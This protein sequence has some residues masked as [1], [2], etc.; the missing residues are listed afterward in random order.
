MIILSFTHFSS[1]RVSQVCGVSI[2]MISLFIFSDLRLNSGIRSNDSEHQFIT[3][4]LSRFTCHCFRS[5][6]LST[7]SSE[8]AVP[9]R[10][11]QTANIIV[12][13]DMQRDTFRD[14]R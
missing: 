1:V 14:G 10:S 2:Q 5:R 6:I 13:I 12:T 11:T 8:P 4:N 7:S 9:G 3:S